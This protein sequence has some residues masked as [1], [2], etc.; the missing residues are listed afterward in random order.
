MHSV[1]V[2]ILPQPPPSM[3]RGAALSPTSSRPPPQPPDAP[4]PPPRPH[5]ALRLLRAA[6][7]AAAAATATQLVNAPLTTLQTRGASAGAPLFA[8]L[9][10]HLLKR[11]PTKTLATLLASLTAPSPLANSLSSSAAL[12][13]TYPLHSCYY[14]ARKRIPLATVRALPRAALYSGVLPALAAAVLTAYIDGALFRRA[15]AALSPHTSTL[16]ALTVAASLSAV[17]AGAAAEP[18]K[19]VAR[20]AAVRGARG[21]AG[22]ASTVAA[23]LLADARAGAGARRLWAGF[24]KRALRYAVAAPVTKVATRAI[25]GSH[26]DS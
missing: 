13:A 5:P 14:A 21:A 3:R 19:A 17:S 4:P 26:W 10:L 11:V 25:A 20:K 2:F 6:A 7:I 16:A 24:G 12:L 9:P 22:G 23:A 18:L 15:R 1:P 8:E